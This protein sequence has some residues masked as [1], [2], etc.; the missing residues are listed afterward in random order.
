MRAG[1]RIADAP[2]AFDVKF[3][4]IVPPKHHVA[5][6]LIASFHQKLLHAGQNHILAH[7]REKFWIPTERSAVRKVVRSCMTSKK[8]RA[9]TMEQMMSTL[10]AFRTTAYEPCFTYTGVD[11]FGPLN[12][13]KERSVVKRWGA[14]FKCMNSRAIHLELATS[15]E[16][17]CF[18]NVFRRFVNRR[19]PPKFMYS[20]NETNF[21]GAEREIRQ[22]IENWNQCQIRDELP[23]ERMS[24]GVSAT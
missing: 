6:L 7:L 13:K 8:Q 9:A 21:L 12:V 15:L 2:I 17:D 5:Q 3:P 23:V 19:G 11:Y 1:G 24:V 14:I 22:A 4:M 20:D 10:P 18:I 16:A